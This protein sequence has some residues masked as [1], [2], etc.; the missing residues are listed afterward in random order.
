MAGG[1]SR[2]VS[3]RWGETPDEEPAMPDLF[4]CPCGVR[5]TVRPE[6]L[7]QKVRCPRCARILAIPAPPVGQVSN[8]PPPEAGWKPAPQRKT[9]CSSAVLERS[10]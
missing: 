2:V 10:L 4:A 6:S 5:L 9:A 3:F 7:G 1:P 8:L